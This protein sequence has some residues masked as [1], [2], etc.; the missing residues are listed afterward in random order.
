MAKSGWKLIHTNVFHPLTDHPMLYSTFP[1]TGVQL[2]MSTFTC[3]VFCLDMYPAVSSSHSIAIID[4][5]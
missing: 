3:T 2:A 4:R 5:R 1:G